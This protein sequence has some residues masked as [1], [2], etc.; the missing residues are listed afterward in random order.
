MAALSTALNYARSSLVTVAGQTAVASQNV[1]NVKNVDYSRKNTT[2]SSQSSGSIAISRYDRATD[3]ILLEKLLN[4]SS[5]SAASNAI[6]DGVK[7]LA[8]TVGDP[9]SNTSPSAMLGKLQN[10]LQTYEQNPADQNLAANAVQAASDI[11]RSLNEANTTIQNVRKQADAGIADG[12]A[13]INNL[14]QQY[15]VVNDSIVRGDISTSDMVDNLDTRDKIIKQLSEAMGIKTVTRAN[16]DVSLYTESGVTLFEKTPRTVTFKSAIGMTASIAGAAV[17]V[18]GVDVTSPT[19]SMPLQSGSIYGLTKLRDSIAVTYQSQIDE[20]ARGLISVFKESPQTAFPALPDATGLFSY[21]GSPSIPASG[22]TVRGLS[23]EIRINP[24]VDPAQ[25]GSLTKLRD[26]GMNGTSYIY[27]SATAS[28]YADRISGL[29]EGLDA[30]QSF[31]PTADLTAQ[32]SLKTYGSSSSGW[33]LALQQKAAASA[34][35]QSAISQRS[36]EA[37]QSKTGV[38]IDE[39][40]STMLEL[41]RSYQAS[42]KLISVVDQML[43]TLLGIVK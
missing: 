17:Y 30:T 32:T 27:N 9:Q 14:L 11:V 42:A 3:T 21:S 38:S 13:K 37:L 15:K 6:V 40:M 16:N 28:G 8:E 10:A 7:R 20:F 22:V 43:Q 29:I 31:D 34:D 1:A 5:N 24:A 18:D 19:S 4:S 36:A 2:V 26:G 33:L 23:G 41:E 35:L 12:V 25:G 39:E